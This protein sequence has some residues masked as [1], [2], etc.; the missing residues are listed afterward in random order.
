MNRRFYFPATAAIVACWLINSAF[1][2]GDANSRAVVSSAPESHIIAPLPRYSFPDQK[3]VYS[4]QWHFF[5]AGT[6]TVEIQHAGPAARVVA[7]ANS[8][9]MPDK[10][11]KVHDLFSA[12]VDPSTFCTRQMQK[13]NEEGKK[14]YEETVAL[15]YLHGKSRVDIK[16][17]KSAEMKH[18]EFDIPSC[19]TDV[20]SGFFYV[21]SLPLAPGYSQTFPVNDNGK[22]TDVE[23]MVESRESIKSPLGQFD[24]LRVKAEPL[25]GPMKGKGVLWVWFSNDRRRIPVQMKSKLGFA[26]LLFQLQQMNP[27]PSGK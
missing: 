10:I 17:T 15:D 6:S 22:T 20:V 4:V 8:S 1:A 5:N 23:V 24:T 14:Q 2:G 3:Y 9:G 16:N 11:F 21:A 26:T 19:V 25:S 12:D 7:T 27:Q 13:H 18:N